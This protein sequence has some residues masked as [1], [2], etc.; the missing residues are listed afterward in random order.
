MNFLKKATE[1][2]YSQHSDNISDICI[3]LPSKRAGVFLTKYLSDIIK[4]PILGP[5]ITTI[6]E[7]FYNSS[8]LSIAD[9]LALIFELYNKYKQHTNSTESFD[10][11]FS[12]GETLLNDFDDIDKYLADAKLLFRNYAEYKEI[13]SGFDFLTETQ[14]E[15]I[16]QF[17]KSFNAESITK[18]QQTFIDLWK[19]LF[20]IY[21]EFRESLA[22]KGLGYEGLIYRDVSENLNSSKFEYSKYIFI[23]FNA[24]N[25]CEKKLM[26]HLNS[27][28][29]ADF[30]W[31]YDTYYTKD[32]LS[33][34][35]GFFLKENLKLFPQNKHMENES[36]LFSNLSS[37]NKNISV[38]SVPSDTGQIEIVNNIL[39]KY[40]GF[41]NLNTAIILGNESMLLPMINT[42]EEI[43]ELNITMGYPLKSSQAY[44]LIDLILNI[45]KNLSQDQERSIHFKAAISY[46]KH[47]FIYSTAPTEIDSLI[48]K[49]KS[50]PR[51]QVSFSEL[52]NLNQ[53]KDF[54]IDKKRIPDIL[55]NIISKLLKYDNSVYNSIERETIYNF[56]I[57][58]TKLNGIIK[59]ENIRFE[60]YSTYFK[61]VK[62]SISSLAIPFTG[63]PL[64]GLQVMGILE[65]RLLDFNNII[66]TSNN[67]GVFP[68]NSPSV[69]HIPHNLRYG[70]GIPTLKHRDAI[71]SYYFYRL[72]QRSK[73]VHLL[74][75]SNTSSEQIS[76]K[77]RFLYQLQYEGIYKV[78]EFNIV[79]DVN[80]SKIVP[81]S[82]EKSPNVQSIIDNIA[83]KKTFSSTALNTYLDCSLKFYFKYIVK[84]REPELPTEDID[85]LMF[86][87]LF[88][89]AAE[90][91][92][93]PWLNKDIPENLFKK[94]LSNSVVEQKIIEAFNAEMP[95]K[96]E[97][98]ENLK[99]KE[100]I[101]FEVIKKYIKALIKFDSRSE[102]SEFTGFETEIE[103]DFETESERHNQVKL[104]AKI[105]R[106]DK[107]K[108]GYRIIDYKTGK[109]N[110]KFTDIDSLFIQDKM[111]NRAMFQLFIYALIFSKKNHQ[112]PQV[113]LLGITD[114]FKKGFKFGITASRQN[115]EEIIENNLEEFKEKLKTLLTEIMSPDTNFEQTEVIET[116]RTCDYNSICF[117][118]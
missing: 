17:W 93:K 46:L 100:I 45:F 112:I 6:N 36:N 79:Y 59:R 101:I 47:S 95:D 90:L 50:S 102:I 113:G 53:F 52:I 67:E 16:K 13:S 20:N 68:K 34:E 96:Y 76:D 14:I 104:Y 78:N 48:N 9:N 2:I 29:K 103:T 65:T 24:L 115:P 32:N 21:K 49:L 38:Y 64:K 85:N 43:D 54:D 4:S 33:H 110:N 108:S 25:S 80:K 30:F 41:A 71:Y 55:E 12:W 42:L 56:Y 69:S 66:I 88:H 39:G 22:N 83:S 62:R 1:I 72:I 84:Y 58:I 92:Y 40:S 74:Y 98:K 91:I 109:A 77:S 18:H 57:H 15:A 27:Q 111:R 44:T 82:V 94:Q 61:L 99:G 3:V 107:T 31:D 106:L 7:L 75:N 114:L 118:Y 5:K 117:R 73:N 26:T 28:D 63:E 11:F 51:S 70:F 37:G 10:S 89:K 19:N 35:A 97:S 81:I 23:G 86:G 116:C 105:D 87:N 60:N 8:K